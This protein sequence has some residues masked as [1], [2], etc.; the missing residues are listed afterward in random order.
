MAPASMKSLMSPSLKV[1]LSSEFFKGEKP[2]VFFLALL[3]PIQVPT[4]GVSE[5][6]R[7]EK[8]LIRIITDDRGKISLINGPCWQ[9]VPL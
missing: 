6:S 9:P 8:P 2:Q 4:Q 5:R 7:G 3:Q 1:D